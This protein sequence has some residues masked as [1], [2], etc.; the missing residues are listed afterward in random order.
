VSVALANFDDLLTGFYLGPEL[1]P[2]DLQHPVV[3]MKHALVSTLNDLS[4][5]TAFFRLASTGMQWRSVDHDLEKDGWAE[6]PPYMNAFVYSPLTKVL[7]PPLAFSY[8]YRDSPGLRGLL[9]AT[10]LKLDL[11]LAG[12]AVD[13]HRVAHGRLPERLDEL[14]PAFLDRVPTDPLN[15]NSPFAC[16]TREDGEFEVYCAR[17]AGEMKI[18]DRISQIWYR[19]LDATFTV[20]PPELRNRPQVA[21]AEGTGT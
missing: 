14:V 21:D 19:R 10:C 5:R 15:G 16:R 12:V 17:P 9:T 20:A 1:N 8:G 7:A 4:G 2:P 18:A 13:R 6:Q 3:R 11:A